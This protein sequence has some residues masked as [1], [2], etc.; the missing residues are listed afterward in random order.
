LS[1]KV[2]TVQKLILYEKQFLGTS[3]LKVCYIDKVLKEMKNKK[4]S[5]SKDSF[6]FY[7]NQNPRVKGLNETGSYQPFVRYIAI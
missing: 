3:I 5:R 6:S 4:E 1:V 2:L 7:S